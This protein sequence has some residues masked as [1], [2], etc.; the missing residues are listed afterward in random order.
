MI[1]LQFK[2]PL[3]VN[4][5]INEEMLIC[6]DSDLDTD[7]ESSSLKSERQNIKQN[8]YEQENDLFLDNVL[9]ENRRIPQCEQDSHDI[10][11]IQNDFEDF[12]KY[13]TTEISQLKET[14]HST[15]ASGK[16]FEKEYLRTEN[17]NLKGE[18]KELRKMVLELVDNTCTRNSENNKMKVSRQNQSSGTTQKLANINSYINST[19]SYY[20]DDNEISEMNK[21]LFPKKPLPINKV[22]KI[23]NKRD[24]NITTKNRFCTLN[25]EETQFDN[26]NNRTEAYDNDET[27]Y[28]NNT[29]NKLN[30]AVINRRP[31]IVTNRNPK[32]QD[33]QGN[34]NNDQANSNYVNNKKNPKKIYIF[35]DSITKRIIMNRF[36]QPLISGKAQRK[37]FPGAKAKELAH[38]I[39][40]TLQEDVP[41]IAVIHVGINDLLEK[42][43][44]DINVL[45]LAEEIIGVGLLCRE[46]NVRDIFISGITYTT[47]VHIKHIRDLNK[48]IKELCKRYNFFFIENDNIWNSHL[49][50]DGLH[51]NDSGIAVIADNF[52]S[53]LNHFLSDSIFPYPNP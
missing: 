53:I 43:D 46:F 20:D 36:N 21:W 39:L 31:K 29:K 19:T 7:Y 15:N 45:K 28:N 3:I 11:R 1:K 32:N 18:V 12:K 52:I 35:S 37:S 51:L 13:I 16:D 23:P 9:S 6:R 41:E 22:K 10:E 33:D 4:M 42:G 26:N 44:K 25:I 17:N 8:Q 14:F 34:I 49:W 47:K 50:K 24:Y 2:L 5:G 38:Y 30:K 40:P 27:S 48:A